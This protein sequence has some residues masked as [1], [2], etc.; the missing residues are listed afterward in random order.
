MQRRAVKYR[1]QRA[2][3]FLASS[4][5]D[6]KST[7]KWSSARCRKQGTGSRDISWSEAGRQ[8]SCPNQLMGRLCRDDFIGQTGVESRDGETRLG[9]EKS[10][11]NGTPSAEKVAGL[12]TKGTASRP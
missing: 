10:R 11:T 7:A 12:R 2:A 9:V 6:S 5:L 4:S 8:Q 1:H 3:D